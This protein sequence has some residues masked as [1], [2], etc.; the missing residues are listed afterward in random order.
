V[1]SKVLTYH[2]V[3]RPL[4]LAVPLENL[5]AKIVKNYKTGITVNPTE[6]SDFISAA[7]KLFEDGKLRD[8][9]G[10]N[11]R[12]YA[13]QHFDIEKITDKFEKIIKEKI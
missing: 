4:L 11:A 9:L 12:K 13:E 6:I 1:P 3:G 7:R 8:K 5:A 10:K 2:C